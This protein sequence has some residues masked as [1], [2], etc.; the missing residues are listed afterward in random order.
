MKR[1]DDFSGP[2]PLAALAAA[3]KTFE[4][5]ERYLPPFESWMREIP[6][7]VRSHTIGLKHPFTKRSVYPICWAQR[8][9][10]AAGDKQVQARQAIKVLEEYCDAGPLRDMCIDWLRKNHNV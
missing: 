3:F 7:A 8:L 2:S 10:D 6:L 5:Y 4:R 1:P 9:V